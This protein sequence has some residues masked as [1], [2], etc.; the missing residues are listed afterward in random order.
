MDRRAFITMVG[1][2]ILAVP[3]TAG[4]QQAA[5]V[6]RI[7]WLAAG[8][9]TGVAPLTDA[10]RRGLRQL[11]Y[12]EGKDIFIEFRYADGNFARLP[13]LAG[14]IVELKVDVIVVANPEAIQATRQ[15]TASIPIVMV[16]LGDPAGLGLMTSLARPDGNIT[17]LSFLS[18]E[19]AGKRLD[20][21]RAAFPKISRVAVL[22]R[23]GSAQEQQ[24]KEIEV[25][26]QA[27]GIHV[28]AVLVQS[29]EDFE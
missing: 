10:F 13:K 4:A 6:Y 26:A 8:S 22:R 15:A 29:P 18:T 12:V 1:G 14:E 2:S 27:L 11:G 25:A 7:G 16:G 19:M 3:L 24:V 20:L 17:G 9:A 5:K 21:L 28:Q 23:S